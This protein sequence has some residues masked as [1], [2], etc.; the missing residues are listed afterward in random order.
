[1]ARW[2]DIGWQGVAY[3]TLPL[4]Q[5]AS[6]YALSRR[7]YLHCIGCRRIIIINNGNNY[8]RVL[9]PIINTIDSLLRPLIKFSCCV[10][11]HSHERVVQGWS[12]VMPCNTPL[13]PTLHIYNT[14]KWTD[15]LWNMKR[16]FH[17][18]ELD[19]RLSLGTICMYTIWCLH[20][21]PKQPTVPK[22][23]YSNFEMSSS[24]PVLQNCFYHWVLRGK[25]ACLKC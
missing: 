3:C 2:H 1:M 8:N 10:S 25:N 16:V 24:R 14:F 21:N 9:W 13:G 4:C 6:S 19:I 17:L 22:Y 5:F 23:M 7:S 12:I 11:S 20:S 18:L 15:R